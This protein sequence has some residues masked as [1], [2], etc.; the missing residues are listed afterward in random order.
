MA[1]KKPDIFL[2]IIWKY[3]QY[4]F[5]TTLENDYFCIMVGNSEAKAKLC[6]CRLGINSNSLVFLLDARQLEQG[7]KL[8]LLEVL[9]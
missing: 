4:L 8:R 5:Y 1:S 2:S 9:F 6:R 3:S 7:L